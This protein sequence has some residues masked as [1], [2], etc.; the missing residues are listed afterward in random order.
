MIRACKDWL[1]CHWPRLRLRTIVF[2]TLFFVAALPGFGAIFLRVY[3]NTLIRQTEAEL[4]AQAAALAATA[5]ADWPAE[6][7]TPPASRPGTGGMAPTV[8]YAQTTKV[9]LSSTAILA[10]RPAPVPSAALSPDVRR[11]GDRLAPILSQT[12][13]TTLASII[14]LDR[15]GRIVTGSAE[16][17]SYANLPEVAAAL[18]G[19]PQTVLRRNGAYHAVYR[20]EW[21]SRAA[22]IRVHHAHPIIVDGQVVGVLLLSRSARALFRGLYEDRGKILFGVLVI[23]GLLVVLSGLLSRGITRPIEELGIATRAVAGGRGTVPP[24][25]KT[26]AI[27]IQ[28]LYADFATMA[29]AIE[30]RSRYLRDLAYAI[31]H[32]FKTPLAGI[33]GVLELLQDHQHD[34]EESDRRR[35]LTNAT[36]DA[37]RLA[38]LITRLLDLARADMSQ[39][40]PDACCDIAA[41]LRHL[42][43]IHHTDGFS[44]QLEVRDGLPPAAIPGNVVEVLFSTLFENSRQAGATHVR[45]TITPW[46]EAELGIRVEDN[47]H[48]LTTADRARMFEPFFTTRRSEGGTGLGLTIAQSLLKAYGGMIAA[49]DSDA[50]AAFAIQIPVQHFCMTH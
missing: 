18:H 6:A 25:P 30:R 19:Q 14:L 5:A 1:K 27:E 22:A 35:F 31:S 23:F 32:E 29:A 3:E 49:A 50:G 16:Q 12:R 26:A 44:I 24:I 34:M 37:D 42:A 43:E 10:E 21:L 2:A 15:H 20:F 39:T 33:R 9:D 36:A 45:V 47:G 40:S 13:A 41:A 46:T 8:P 28:G 48:G 4:I 7:H 11:A 38:L 17:G